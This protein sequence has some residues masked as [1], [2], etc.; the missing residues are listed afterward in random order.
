MQAIVARIKAEHAVVVDHITQADKRLTNALAARAQTDGVLERL[1]FR[2]P[3]T[4]VQTPFGVA[5][6][7][8]VREVDAC[9]VLTPLHWRSTFFFSIETL[10]AHEAVGRDAACVAMTAEERATRAF[11]R[12]EAERARR[13]TQLM[14]CEDALVRTIAR[15]RQKKEA[16]EAIVRK[17]VEAQELALQLAYERSE[18]KTLLQAAATEAK[19]LQDAPRVSLKRRTKASAVRVARSSRFDTMRVTRA[20]EKRLAMASIEAALTGT[21]ASLR[22]AFVRERDALYVEDLTADVF[23]ELCLELMRDACQD[24]VTDAQYASSALDR[25]LNTAIVPHNA[26]W[27]HVFTHTRLGFDRLWHARKTKCALVAQT[28]R[29]EAAK[30]EILQADIARREELERLADE[31][32]AR[33]ELRRREMLAEER[34]CRQFYVDEMVLYMQERKAMAR[35]ETETREYVRLLALEAM[36][37]KYAKMVEDRNHTSDKAARR[38]EIKLGKNEKHRLHRE[39]LAIAHEDELATQIR[40]RELAIA[41]AEAL[42]RQFDKYLIQQAIDGRVAAALEA[43]RLRERVLEAQRL[44]AAKRAAFEAKLVQERMVATVTAFH[45][46][47]QAEVA[48]MDSVERAAYWLEQLAPLATTLQQLEPELARIVQEREHV[49]ADA[50]LKREHA[51]KC[52]ARLS[53][54]T[55]ALA[56][57]IQDEDASA[58]AYK[59]IHFVTA[60]MDSEVLHGRPQRFRTTYLRARLHDQYFRLLT[61]SIVRRA[62]VTCSEREVARLEHELV[63]LHTERVVKSREVH[64]LKRKH[65]RA[66]HMS[67]RRAELGKLLFGGS[68]RRLVRTMFQQWVKLWSQRVLV[69]ASFELKHSLVLQQRRLQAPVVA[70]TTLSHDAPTKL[71]LLQDFQKRRQVCRLCKRE[72]AET[73]NHALACAY[74]PQPYELACVRSCP[75]RQ[76]TS[77]SNASGSA[78]ITASCMLHRAKRWLCCDETDEGRFGSSGCARRYH[79]PTRANPALAT[80]VATK[81]ATEATRLE[82]ID[83]QLLELRER[84]VVGQLRGTTKAVITQIER[85]LADQRTLAAKYHTLDRR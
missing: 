57:A 32:R 60:T 63:R 70:T 78:P 6:V 13:E 36:K 82:Q 48:W 51:R 35:A 79:M 49:V 11:D 56:Q 59:K 2:S 4:L 66:Y 25:A 75:S 52:Q 30:L 50:R 10:V 23:D 74:H 69:R 68:Q 42:E 54:A 65:R 62:I 61:E 43:S 7:L 47:A 26:V 22:A 14:D 40:E 12:L 83:Q 84:N 64:R 18:R 21:D 8:Y 55:A 1:R 45:S 38:L 33:L 15:W 71:S 73:Q 85:E 76:R 3:G 37:T 17:A 77:N 28:W 19:R 20:S 16:E 58:K 80:L 67:L 5:R 72:Y 39:W 46:V 31:E 44:A 53:L 27:T 24:A 29:R 41:Q 34:R 9:V 81:S